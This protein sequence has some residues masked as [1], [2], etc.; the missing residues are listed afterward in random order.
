MKMFEGVLLVFAFFLM[1]GCSGGSYIIK[2]TGSNDNPDGIL[3]YSPQPYILVTQSIDPKKPNNIV[4]IARII[5]LPDFTNKH[6]I[7]AKPG[8]GTF[9]GN[10]TLADGWNLTAIGQKS[11]AKVPE[12]ISAISSIPNNLL[13]AII[14]VL[15]PSI[16]ATTSTK[17][18]QPLKPFRLFKIDTKNDRITELSIPQ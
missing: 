17:Q 18:K 16:Q 6:Y 12:T 15:K 2:N 5:Y 9:D 1:I 11:D 8:S 7:I 13:Y 3:Y 14:K 10:I 4:R